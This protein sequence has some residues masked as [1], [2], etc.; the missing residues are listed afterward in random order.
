MIWGVL[1]LFYEWQWERSTSTMSTNTILCLVNNFKASASGKGV[2]VLF[3]RMKNSTSSYLQVCKCRRSTSTIFRLTSVIWM[4]VVGHW[5]TG[6]ILWD[7]MQPTII[8]HDETPSFSWSVGNRQ[9]TYFRSIFLSN[10]SCS[11][12][13]NKKWPGPLCPW[14]NTLSCAL[15]SSNWTASRCVGTGSVASV[16]SPSVLVSFSP[17]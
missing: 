5:S 15:N 12:S 1:V 2:L 6:T 14:G 8:L 9:G 13:S 3:F 11:I 17:Q 4:K 16:S 7:E 10:N